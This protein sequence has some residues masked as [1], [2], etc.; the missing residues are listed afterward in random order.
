M[1][2]KDFKNNPAL[3]FISSA[4]QEEPEQPAAQTEE[5][6]KGFKLNPMYIETKSKRV[7]IL[8]QPSVFE[9]VDRIARAK[10]ISRNEAINEALR[11]YAEKEG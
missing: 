2:K 7:Q 3:Q 5:P 8:V 10:G 11:Q 1:A 6:P 9:T 4:S